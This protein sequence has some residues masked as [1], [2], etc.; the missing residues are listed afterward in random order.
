MSL[1]GID[2][3]TTGVKAAAFNDRGEV[4]SYAYREYAAR[5]P[6][7]GWVELDSRQVLQSIKA[8]ISE[9]A[10]AVSA[11]PISAICVSAMGEAATPVDAEGRIL[12]DCI[13]SSDTRGRQ[14]AQ[15]LDRTL[16]QRRVYRI[17]PNVLSAAYTMPKLCWLRDNEPD[18]YERAD[19][20]LLWDGM[21]ALALG[22]EP[23][24]SYSHANRTLLFDIHRQ[25]WSDDLLNVAGLDAAKLPRCLPAGAVAGEVS[26]AAASELGLPARVKLVVGGHDQCCG[27][28]G[29]GVAAP[30]QAVDGIGT[31]ECI[32]PVYD[33]IPDGEAMLSVGLNVEHHVVEGLY[34]S[35]LFNQAGSLVRW[36]RDTFAPE[37]RDE[38]GIYDS[39]ASEMPEAPTRLFTLPYFE[40]TGSPDYVA[41]ASGV[42][43]GLKLSTTRGEILKSIMESVTYYFAD[44]LERLKARGIAPTQFVATGGGARSDAWLQIKADVY[45]APLARPKFTECGLMGAAILA[46]QAT[47]VLGPAAETARQWVSIDRRFT[48]DRQRHEIY[49]RRL[50]MYR[51]LFPQMRACGSGVSGIR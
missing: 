24:V 16:G 50:E 37:R 5:Y 22:C 8:V 25:G 41:D 3:G 13:L 20:F 43:V 44:G 11:D 9:T 51:Q 27:A 46:G 31:Y 19:K 30:G 18:I 21:V 36:F 29:A 40:P 45:G 17:N 2:I 26:D 4:L 14:Y 28:L 34:V 10:V 38:A 15:H 48:P 42:I 39:L 1:L 47:G 32:T 23:L 33:R 6:R 49:A 35:F 12:R 7:P